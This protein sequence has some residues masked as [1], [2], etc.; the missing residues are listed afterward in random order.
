MNSP[1]GSNSEHAKNQSAYTDVNI[2][3]S[4]SGHSSR[5]TKSPV[6]VTTNADYKRPNSTSTAASQNDNKSV[7]LER[8]WVGLIF[9]SIH[10]LLGLVRIHHA[11]YLHINL[12]I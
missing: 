1:S 7:S 11:N 10:F 3:H 4:I 5:S 12:L 6:I 2:G 9:L 8:N